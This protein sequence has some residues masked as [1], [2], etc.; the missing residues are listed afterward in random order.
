MIKMKVTR[1]TW[2]SG[3][4]AAVTKKASENGWMKQFMF[5]ANNSTNAITYT[6]EVIDPDDTATSLYSKASLAENASTLTT[7]LT[8]PIE[9]DFQIKV[10]PSGDP[11]VSG[12]IVDIIMYLE[13]NK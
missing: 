9:K 5:K 2:A 1:M 13:Q 4:T 12:G 11:G 3:I 10:T 7:G 8:V 6:I